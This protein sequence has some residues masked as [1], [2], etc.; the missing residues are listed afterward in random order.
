MGEKLTSEHIERSRGSAEAWLTEM[1]EGW[2][3]SWEQEGRDAIRRGYDAYDDGFECPTI[4]GYEAL[5]KDGFVE[6]IGVVLKGR[7]ERVHFRLTPA[8]R[9]ALSLSEGGR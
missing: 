7:E 5:E 3:R 6:R 4:A 1:E 8:G 2:P 9:A